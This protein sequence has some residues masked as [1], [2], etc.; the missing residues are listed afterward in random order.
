MYDTIGHYLVYGLGGPRFF[1]NI[2]QEHNF[3]TYLTVM[4]AQF[5]PRRLLTPNYY[6]VAK[7]YL[8][9]RNI[10]V[11]AL[12]SLGVQNHIPIWNP[13]T[14]VPLPIVVIAMT[15][16]FLETRIYWWKLKIRISVHCYQYVL[17]MWFLLH[18]K[19]VNFSKVEASK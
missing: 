18:I 17:K 15:P 8:R 13:L 1:T 3:A 11:E 9:S 14:R 12:D 4:E 19:I 5:H 7:D 16:F 10:A 2:V 6:D